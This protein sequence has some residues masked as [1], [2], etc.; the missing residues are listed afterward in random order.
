MKILFSTLASCA[1]FVIAAAAQNNAAIR[2]EWQ[3]V[4]S[5]KPLGLEIFEPP[6]A[7]TNS[8][9]PVVFY[10]KNLSA[11]RVGT[12]SDDSIRQWGQEN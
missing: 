3:G 6:G 2:A 7:Q 1:M 5:D 11:P 10:L 4:A 12:E 8:T 9:L